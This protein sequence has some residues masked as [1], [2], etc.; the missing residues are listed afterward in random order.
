MVSQDVVISE[1]DCGTILGIE[2]E[3][4]KEG[5]E[6]V[7]SLADRI[8][9]RTVQDDVVDPITGERIVEAG[10]LLDEELADKNWPM[11]V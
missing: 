1:A 5:E 9:G 2:M 6:V 7:E 11:Q 10:V 3:A 4:L 8:V